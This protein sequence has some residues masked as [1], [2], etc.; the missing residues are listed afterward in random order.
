MTRRRINLRDEK[1]MTLVFVG[2]SFVALMTCAMLALDVGQMM[3][4]RSQSQNAADAGALA[5]AVALVFD[6]F[7][8]RSATGPAVQNAITAAKTSNQVINESADVIAADVTF[9]ATEKVRVVVHRTGARGNPLE[10]FLGPMFNIDTANVGAVAVAEVVPA[11]AA[12][13]IKPWAIPDKWMEMQTGPEWDETDTLSM[14]Y[15]NGPNK[16]KPIPNPDIY[17]DWTKSN[18]TGFRPEKDGPDY[19]RKLVLKPG[20]PAGAINPSAFFP[21]RLPGGTGAAYYEKNIWDCWPGTAKIGD[22]MTVEPGSMVGPTGQGTNALINSDP[23]A[24]WNDA[25]KGVVN[26]KTIPSPRIVVL[27]VFDPNVYEAARQTGAIDIT[28]ANFV[29]FFIDDM[30]GNTVTGHMVPMTGL[31]AGGGPV[32]PGAYLSAI[33]LVE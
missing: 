30:S 31:V 1:G 6:S 21:I 28:I 26:A 17:H 25:K 33:R 23:G 32:S 12:T 2:M 5:G 22:K 11:N 15:E 8:D 19:A 4:A 20:T 24:S 18:Y 3:V 29:G 13:C 10:L 27:P 9:P 16:G 14:Y 7:N